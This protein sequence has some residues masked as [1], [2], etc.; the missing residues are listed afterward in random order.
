[1]SDEIR[2]RRV[3]SPRALTDFV[4]CAY[5][6]HARDSLWVPMPRREVR[7]LLDRDRHPFHQHAEVEYFT[8]WRDGECVG[9]IAAIENHAH[10]AFH[11][12]RIG[13]F[14]FLN[15][16]P[17]PEIFA[18]LL[19]TAERWARERGLTHLRGP[20][21]FSS[22]E[23]WGLL[24]DG[25]QSPPYIM[26]PW[27]PESYPP[28][29]EAAGYAKCR[30][31]YSYWLSSHSCDTRMERIAD[32]VV[33][34][35]AKKGENVVVR[36]MRI[37]DFEGELARVRQVYNSAWE[38]NW[39]FIP[40]TGAELNQMAR[41]LKMVIVPELVQIV[42]INGKPAGI[43]FSLPDYNLALRH[44]EGR[45]GPKQL[46]LFLA[47]KKQI[48]Q[49]RVLAMGVVKEHRNRGLE[50]LLVARTIRNGISLGYTVAELGWILDDNDRMNRELVALGCVRYKTHRIY[51][52][53]LA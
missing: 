51:E 52:K 36:S 24:V 41:D 50:A 49:I 48:K 46:L 2:I 32:R 25:F 15:A 39:G 42:E 29:V 45:L 37:D 1:M 13:F 22:N 47:M 12:E 38:K 40:M 17:E 43:S 16:L 19:R 34:R 9:R 6:V 5:R 7:L 26:T 8:A 21:S 23:E 28:L 14:G 30:D 31:L 11:E 10:N 3:R 44:M 27:N 33:E 53:A 20:A 35:M 4:E 18:A